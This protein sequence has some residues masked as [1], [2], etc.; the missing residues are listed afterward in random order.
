MPCSPGIH[1]SPYGSRSVGRVVTPPTLVPRQ[2]RSTPSRRSAR[3][4][5]ALAKNPNRN[6]YEG[7]PPPCDAPS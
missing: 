4:L 6:H 2:P 1:S 7:F 3:H 5:A